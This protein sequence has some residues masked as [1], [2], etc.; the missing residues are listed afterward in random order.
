[1]TDSEQSTNFAEY[2]YE[3]AITPKDKMHR[4]LYIAGVVLFILCLIGIIAQTD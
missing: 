4:F 1:M 2:S 3:K